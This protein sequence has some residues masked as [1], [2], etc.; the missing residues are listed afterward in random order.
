MLPNPQA[1]AAPLF[2]MHFFYAVKRGAPVRE[3]W[4]KAS[5]YDE[6][7]GL[8]VLYDGEGRHRA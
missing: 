3:A 7:S 5:L 2:V 1:V 8:F 4:E 6:D